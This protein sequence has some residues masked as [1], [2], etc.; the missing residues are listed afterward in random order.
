ML[1]V[2][3]YSAS[4]AA[5]VKGV[6]CEDARRLLVAMWHNCVTVDAKSYNVAIS[7]C[8][9]GAQLHGESV[10]EWHDSMPNYVRG[11]EQPKQDKDRC[12]NCHNALVELGEG[13]VLQIRGVTAAAT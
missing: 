11:A 1:D 12:A 7:A 4:I 3:S 8:G 13:E 6:Q 5:R 2:I 10:C 9:N